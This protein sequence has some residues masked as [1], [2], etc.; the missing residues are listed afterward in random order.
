M[1]G[2]RSISKSWLFLLAVLPLYLTWTFDHSLWNPDETR[3]AGIAAEMFR[4]GDYIVPKLNGEPFLEKPPLY[5]W[6]SAVIYK[7]SGRVTAGTTRLPA[8]LYGILGVLFT[9]LIGKRLFNERVGLIGAS[10]LA[11]SFQYF[12]MSHFAMMDIPLAA[13]VTGALFFH[14]K[15]SKLGFAVFTVLAFFAKGFLGIVLPGIVVSLDLIT[16]KRPKDL[17]KT[18][19]VGALIFMALAGPWLWGLWKAGGTEFLKIFLID[20]HWSRF[21]SKS[22]DH[23]EHFWFFYFLSFPV[24]FLPW[25]PLFLGP[26]RDLF[27]RAQKYIGTQSSRFLLLWFLGLLFFFTVSSSKRSIYLLPLFPA[28]ALLCGV[29]LDD[30][31]K[32]AAK[33]ALWEKRTIIVFGSMA[34]IIAVSSFFLPSILDRDKS[35]VPVCDAI[36]QNRKSGPVVGYNLNEMERGVFVF[37]LGGPLINPKNSGQFENLMKEIETKSFCL[38]VNRNKMDEIKKYL[39]NDARLVY[40][41]RPN[42]KTRSYRVYTNP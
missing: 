36:I 23:T 2:E 11:T 22:A 26:I 18:I 4:G 35:F 27:K 31:L 20:N 6:T 25:S 21:V 30:M 24:D 15:G 32:S 37:Y 7:L 10:L 34:A 3:D 14:L 9:F 1:Q 39:P 16:Q 5:Y 8:A 12:R 13:L 17:I 38:V 33:E 40:E 28:A 29:S 42:K 19:G 41:H